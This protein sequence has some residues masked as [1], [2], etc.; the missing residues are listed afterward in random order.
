MQSKRKQKTKNNKTHRKKDQIWT[1]QRHGIGAG[2][3]VRSGQKIQ[4]F[5]YKINK[6]QGYNVQHSD[7]S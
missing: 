6:Y 5:S 3:I 2:A 1:Y 7:C 4:A